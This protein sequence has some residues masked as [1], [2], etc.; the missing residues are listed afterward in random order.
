[1]DI[2][3]IPIYLRLFTTSITFI[4]VPTHLYIVYCNQ[5]ERK[6]CFDRWKSS[7]ACVSLNIT[8][9]KPDVKTLSAIRNSNKNH[10]KIHSSFLIHI[11]Q[12][13]TFNFKNKNKHL[14]NNISVALFVSIEYIIFFFFVFSSVNNFQHLD[15][16]NL[17]LDPKKCLPPLLYIYIVLVHLF[18]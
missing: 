5:I 11:I 7:V 13:I 6:K 14:L 8:N 10:I 17:A 2:W 3:Q 15:W 9:Y 12:Y 16:K 18:V 1:M 4:I